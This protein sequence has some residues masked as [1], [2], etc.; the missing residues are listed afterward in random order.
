M[1]AITFTQ[2]VENGKFVV[3]LYSPDL[4]G[5]S[6]SF[7]MNF[8]YTTTALSFSKIVFDGSSSTSSS[9]SQNNFGGSVAAAGQ[10][11]TGAGATQPFATLEFTGAGDGSFDLNFATLTFNG[12]LANYIDPPATSFSIINV[13]DASAIVVSE[14]SDFSQ[15]YNPFHS[16]F[17]PT[18]QVALHPAHGTVTIVSDL[19]ES[20]WNYVP[21]ANYYGTDNFRIS[22]VDGSQSKS[23]QVSVSV[24]P[25]N[26]AP[27]GSVTISGVAMA[28]HV[29]A[30]STSTLGD[31]DG[32]GPISYQWS[33]DGNPVAG[34]TSSTFAVTDAQVGNA[35]AVVATYIDGGGTTERVVSSAFGPVIANSPASLI[36][37]TASNDRLM[38]I[39]GDVRIDAAAGTDTVVFVGNRGDYV[40]AHGD[41]TLTVAGREG[42]ATLLGVE[43]LQFADAAIAFDVDGTAGKAF[44]TYQ[45]AFDRAPDA[46]GLGFWINFMDAGMSL[47]DVAAGFMASSEF[48]TMYGE[49]PSHADFVDK[50]YLNVLHRQGEPSGV[51]FWMTALDNPAISAASV[52]AAFAE[53]HE[54][55]VALV[56][57]TGNGMNYIPFG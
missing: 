8:S 41:A 56:G 36:S 7:A 24:T 1:P 42:A 44:R 25:V 34:A 53:S 26:D 30:A 15:S 23:L 28:G 20:K 37:G 31:L 47:N 18:L 12:A 48:K 10:F 49:N 29:V 13:P 38:V 57:V 27:S 4:A 21:D 45:A 55:Q 9:S 2:G 5:A 22:A 16:F 43:R 46:A 39:P 54:N 52:L 50:L 6:T 33:A 17:Q 19:F 35:I 40:M 14:D 32:L 3:K 51:A 11:S